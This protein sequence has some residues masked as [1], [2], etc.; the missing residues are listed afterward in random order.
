M[1][2][3]QSMLHAR[4]YH[5]PVALL[6]C[7]VSESIFAASDLAHLDPRGILAVPLRLDFGLSVALSRTVVRPPQLISIFTG[8][9]LNTCLANWTNYH[10][11]LISVTPDAAP[12]IIRSSVSSA[13]DVPA[14]LALERHKVSLMALG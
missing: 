4:F 5:A 10:V 8:L 6:P 12:M 1:G 2:F 3:G 7:D 14:I 9:L 13:K 11:K